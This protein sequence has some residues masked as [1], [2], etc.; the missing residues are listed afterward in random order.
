MAL[1]ALQERLVRKKVPLD[2]MNLLPISKEVQYLYLFSG[3]V[4]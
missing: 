2:L 1:Q 4:L 3:I